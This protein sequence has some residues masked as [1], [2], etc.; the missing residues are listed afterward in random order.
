MMTRCFNS[1][2]LY[3]NGW[4]GYVYGG[5]NTLML[6]TTYSPRIGRVALYLGYY[7]FSTAR[8]KQPPPLL[9]NK[10]Q[11]PQRPSVQWLKATIV[12]NDDD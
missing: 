2:P 4:N 9:Q 7:E 6:N 3:S 12:A 11:S 1:S 8:F 5:S 10:S